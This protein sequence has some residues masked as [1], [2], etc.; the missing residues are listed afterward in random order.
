[1]ELINV[2]EIEETEGYLSIKTWGQQPEQHML[3]PN[4]AER[5]NRLIMKAEMLWNEG[6]S[7]QEVG[8]RMMVAES[9]IK[10][11]LR[12]LINPNYLNS[13]QNPSPSLHS[14]TPFIRESFSEENETN[15][16]THAY[17]VSTPPWQGESLLNS[18]KTLQQQPKQ[19]PVVR[20][21]L[22]GMSR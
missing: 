7:C 4:A 14:G 12:P 18:Q 20:V 1:M 17:G 15:P 10:S 19:Q 16:L 13:P 2:I 3:P 5:K 11:W 21:S 8:E 9:T 22:P 6:L